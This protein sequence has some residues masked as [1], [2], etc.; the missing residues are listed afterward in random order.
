V[1]ARHA[2]SLS[3]FVVSLLTAGC[4]GQSGSLPGGASGGAGGSVGAGGAVPSGTVVA[5]SGPQIPAGWTLCDGRRTPSGQ[6]TPDLRGRFVLGADTTAA[7][8]G[9]SGGSA[10]HVHEAQA[11]PGR[12]S[13]G[14]EEDDVFSVSTSGHSH[15][16][17][18]QPGDSLPPYVKLIY[19]MKD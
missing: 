8:A 5:F 4:M 16:V 13:R 1:H 18:V 2:A 7:D 12:G 6:P 10:T 15:P 17:T 14:T 3:L 19:I 11:G 9:Q